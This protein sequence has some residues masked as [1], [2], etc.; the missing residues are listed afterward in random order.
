M[1]KALLPAAGAAL[2]ALVATWEGLRTNAYQDI[3]GV[4]TVC[5]GETKG[6]KRGDTYT[7]AECDAMLQRE[8]G[9]YYRKLEP[10]LNER[11]TQNQRIA[12]TSLAY[13]IG[14]SAACKSTA[15]RKLNAGDAKGGCDALLMWSYAGGKFVQG[16][17]NRREAERKIC[18]TL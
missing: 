9:E 11:V 6:V 3:V 10:C 15:V 7:K 8:L 17:R 12:V 18:L 1:K 13:N 14:I 4:W 5:Y 16:L 2:L